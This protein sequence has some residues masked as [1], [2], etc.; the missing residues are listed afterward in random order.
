[1]SSSAPSVGRLVAWI[2]GLVIVATPFAAYVWETLNH[3]MM[4]NVDPLG[5]LLAAPALLG[6]LGIW[7]QMWRAIQRWEGER[8]RGD[9]TSGGAS[10]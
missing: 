4:G 8:Q 7:W 1:M 10:S 5:L 9:S 3:L 2:F 6:L